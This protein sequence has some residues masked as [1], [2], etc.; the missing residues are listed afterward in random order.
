MF[1]VFVKHGGLLSTQEAN[2]RGSPI[3][4]VPM[5]GDQSLNM[6]RS[7]TSGIGVLLDYAN[8]TTESVI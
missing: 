2:N 1:Q 3:V 4:E 8:I 7:V 5:Y 6:V